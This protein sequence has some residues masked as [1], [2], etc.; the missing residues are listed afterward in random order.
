MAPTDCSRAICRR[1]SRK[2]RPISA[3]FADC[4]PTRHELVGAGCIPI[5]TTCR[6]W[7]CHEAQRSAHIN[8]PHDAH[9][10]RCSIQSRPPQNNYRQGCGCP[11]YTCDECRG[12]DIPGWKSEGRWIDSKAY[13]AA[14]A[15]NPKLGANATPTRSCSPAS[16]LLQVGLQVRPRR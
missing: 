4:H 11:R 3:G 5:P 1:P 12:R 2:M 13:K 14:D 9:P 16:R 7:R 15:I 8:H 6:A 10:R